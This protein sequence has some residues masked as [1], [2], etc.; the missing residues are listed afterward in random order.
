MDDLVGI[1]LYAVDNPSVN[2]PIN[3]AAPNPETMKEFSKHIGE[4]LRRPSWM[5]VPEFAVKIAVGEVANAILGGRRALP[6]KIM[7][8]GY[9][10]KFIHAI[11]A[12]KDV[13][14]K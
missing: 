6:K 5:P 4:A 8:L 12:L 2:G 1:F 11:D 10:F 3:A 14:L 9:K 7:D 13:V